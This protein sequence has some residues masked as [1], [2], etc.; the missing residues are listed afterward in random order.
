MQRKLSA[1][2]IPDCIRIG[3]QTVIT[4]EAMKMEHSLRT[5][6]AGIVSEVRVN[7]GAQV[8]NGEVLAVVDGDEQPVGSA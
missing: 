7:P 6:Y 8:A 5:P 4:I 2:N 3:G 1:I